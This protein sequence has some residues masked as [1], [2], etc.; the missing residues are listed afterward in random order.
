VK[1]LID[2]AS[3]SSTVDAITASARA[4]FGHDLFRMEGEDEGAGADTGQLP[5]ADELTSL[6]DEQ[7][8][9]REQAANDEADALLER[10]D[11]LTD[12]EAARLAQLADFLDTVSADRTRRDEVAAERQANIDSAAERIAAS[13]DG[14]EGDEGEGDEGA[15]DGGDGG[16]GDGGEGEGEGDEGDAGDTARAAVAAGGSRPGPGG[17]SRVRAMTRRTRPAP[18]PAAQ[19]RRRRTQLVAAANIPGLTAGAQ[20]ETMRDVAEAFIARSQDAFPIRGQYRETRPNIYDKHLVAS[21]VRDHAGI[22]GADADE[23]SNRGLHITEGMDEERMYEVLVAAAN[24]G[25]L[26][27]GSLIASRRN[28]MQAVVAAASGM[29]EDDYL[30]ALAGSGGWCAPSE[31]MYDMTAPET[32]D[33]IVDLPEVGVSRGGVRFTEGPDFADIFAGAGFHQTEAQAIAGETKD[34]VEVTCPDFDEVRL[35][36][37]GLCVKAPL[38]TNAAYPELVRRWLSGTQIANEHKVAA[39]LLTAMDNSLTT[40]ALDY[41]TSAS[42][43]PLAWGLLSALEL[44]AEAE[45]QARRL[46][47]T[48]EMEV[49]V[50]RWVLPA[51]RADL[52]N[53]NEVG[54]D[55]ISNA[56][57]MQHFMDRNLAPQFVL[58]W[59]EL[60]VDSAGPKAY[61]ASVKAL[62]Y[63]AGTFVKGT[64]DVINL[65]T[66][67]DTADLQTNVFTAAF[68]EDGVLLAKMRPG[69]RRILFPVNPNGL[70]A[71]NAL[72]DNFG[73]AQA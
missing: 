33:G 10:R 72:N 16:E 4:R 27:G 31:T 26:P 1:R 42:G 38:L 57:I 11:E 64:A 22:Y 3:I 17:G 63:P 59:Q 34:C 15:G 12:D 51:L 44:Q 9:E 30:R 28:R 68:V 37:V 60:T 36:A 40:G 50:P 41:T 43:T 65:S 5:T 32:L 49:V 45:R 14:G 71:A 73:S 47:D 48:Q 56:R 2:P 52:A 62:I 35:D 21:I 58:N 19:A 18:R 53:R 24:P 8:D 6:S 39:R 66:V 25:R 29:S 7:L 46:S 70:M 69:G 20:L 61:P 67:Y 55:S 23:A 13:R 54:A